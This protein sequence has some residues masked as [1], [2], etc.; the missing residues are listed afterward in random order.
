MGDG[1][2]MGRS[3]VIALCMVSALGGCGMLDGYKQEQAATGP[4]AM[5]YRFT[6]EA[7]YQGKPFNIDQM[8]SC[9]RGV[10]S[11]GFLGQ[12]PDTETHEG[13][14]KTAAAKM[15]DGSQILI[16]IPNMCNQQRAFTKKP[17]QPFTRFV[18]GWRSRGPHEIIPLV[19]WT[20]NI[21]KPERIEAYVARAYYA[22]PDARVKAPKG[23]VE[24]WPLGKYPENYE[25]VL[26]QEDVLPFYPHPNV[27]P[28]DTEKYSRYYGKW[29]QFTTFEITP[30][31]DPI[32][33]WEK[34]APDIVKNG[35]ELVQKKFKDPG[36]GKPL[37]EDE[38]FIVYRELGHDYVS[39]YGVMPDPDY[40]SASCIREGVSYLMGGRPVIMGPSLAKDT[41]INIDY[42][43]P[44]TELYNDTEAQRVVRARHQNKL[45]C[46][47]ALD[48]L[49]SHEIIEGRFDASRSLPGLL[50]YGKWGQSNSY[51]A[52]PSDSRAL[53][54]LG[55]IE[56]T[57]DKWGKAQKYLRFRIDGIAINGEFG[58]YGD[59]T[60]IKNK[61]TGQWYHYL[62][63]SSLF[64]G[65]RESSGFNQ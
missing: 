56:F 48:N 52:F 53:E 51:N 16:R 2:V 7:E 29:S 9:Q 23:Q 20:D 43:V 6:F 63:S 30:I 45:N 14:P 62:A 57:K 27:R 38:N 35:N 12:S 44:G 32:K 34:Y 10:V 19:I 24:L 58:N 15:A 11:G 60:L 65:Q 49:R 31:S 37:Y 28:K 64:H 22:H 50:V 40:I 1:G 5:W 17:D 47:A 36:L 46:F 54:E 39:A 59:W 8:V 18:D 21:T 26:K 55:M 61:K 42:R 41:Y 4:D 13:H 25:G 3:I 33:A